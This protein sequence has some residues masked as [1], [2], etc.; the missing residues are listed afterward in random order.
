M[1]QPTREKIDNL[2]EKVRKLEA[3][4]D[5]QGQKLDLILKLLQHEGE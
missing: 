4:I 3:R 5:D 2:K 1:S